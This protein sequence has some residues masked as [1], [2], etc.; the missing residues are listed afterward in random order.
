MIKMLLPFLFGLI[1]M[2]ASVQAA[3]PDDILGLWSTPENKS[4]IE[5][6]KCG[7]QYCGR[8]TELKEPHYPPDDKRGMAGQIKV[9]RN[10][11][12]P[13]LRTR[14]L[15]GLQLMEGFSHN[16]DSV[17]EGG[18]IYDPE[19]G[20]SYRCKMSLTAPNRL[21]VR[22]FIGISLIGRTSVWTR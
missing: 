9:D 15:V 21:E 16:G 6:F 2:N 12:D 7:T 1:L 18:T 20:K 11:P 10:N 4:K 8:I 3:G 17:W 5:I 22:G 13:I 19:N 14:P